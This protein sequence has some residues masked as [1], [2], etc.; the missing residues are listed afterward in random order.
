MPEWF[1]RM[2]GRP[3]LE[4]VLDEVTAW[5]NVLSQFAWFKLHTTRH[6][7]VMAELTEQLFAGTLST[8][9]AVILWLHY[10]KLT[11]LYSAVSQTLLAV[12]ALVF[13]SALDWLYG[14]YVETL[15]F[16]VIFEKGFSRTARIC[17]LALQI[18]LFICFRNVGQYRQGILWSCVDVRLLLWTRMT[19]LLITAKGLLLLPVLSGFGLAAIIVGP[20]I[21]GISAGEADKAANMLSQIFG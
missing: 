10:L 11:L 12:P 6:E 9:D 2:V 8:R 5:G 19:Q 4:G 18:L 7:F 14:D 15:P 21:F 16:S 13:W 3:S 20:L 1:R 17:A